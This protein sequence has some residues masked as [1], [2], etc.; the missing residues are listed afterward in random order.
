MDE[1][2]TRFRSKIDTAKKK[3]KN[4]TT[5][6]IVPKYIDKIQKKLL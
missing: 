3:Q 6:N 2:P 5:N 4:K 1:I